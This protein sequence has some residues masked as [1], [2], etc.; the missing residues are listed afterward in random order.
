MEK[1]N[2]EKWAKIKTFFKKNGYYFLIV[3]CIGAVAT[4][5][6]V[7]VSQSKKGQD[8]NISIV[9]DSQSTIVG[10]QEKPQDGE[11]EKPSEPD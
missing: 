1:N 11:E 3:L 6:G 4:M 2:S 7:A 5:V 8:A 9:D 10:E